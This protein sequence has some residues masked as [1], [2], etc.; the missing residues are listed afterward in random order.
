MMNTIAS[1][2][3][4]FVVNAAQEIIIDPT[5]EM[6]VHVDEKIGQIGKFSINCYKMKL[7]KKKNK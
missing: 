3:I 4:N 7:G 5:E 6:I 1:D 2:E